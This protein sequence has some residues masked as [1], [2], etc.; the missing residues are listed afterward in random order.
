M[1]KLLKRFSKKEIILVLVC[2]LFIIGQVWLDLK[3]PDYM[4]NITRLVQTEGTEVIEILEQGI[5]MLLCAGGSLIFACIVGYFA[6][7]LSSSFSKELRYDLFCKVEDFSMAEMNKFSISS[8]ITRTTN[9]VTQVEMLIAMGLQLIIKA[10]ITAVWAVMKILGK[11]LLWSE[12]TGGAV[13]I[14]LL[15]IGI[16]MKF[17]Y[18]NFKKVQ[19]L[20]DNVNNVTRENLTGLRVVRAFNAEKYQENK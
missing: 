4:S 17:V 12:I 13:I 18:P 1:L 11:N 15:T 14:L 6:S 9:D 16:L 20:I 2:L 5:Y 7:F 8:L 10:P 3:M 19:N